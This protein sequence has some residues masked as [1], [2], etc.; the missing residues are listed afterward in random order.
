VTHE[1]TEQIIERLIRALAAQLCTSVPPALTPGAVEALTGLSRAEANL[2]FS[3]AGHLVH[4]DADTEPVEILLQLI[5]DIQRRDAA[6]D[7]AIMP[8]DEVRLVGE[9]PAS[10]AGYDATSL[11]ETV[12]VVRYVGDDATID[13]Q[14]D[15]TEDYLIETV[16]IANV[17][18]VRTPS[19]P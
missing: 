8:G 17:K 9:P 12:F 10:L 19:T 15:L 1:A 11:R 4:Y 3:H 7:A 6:A 2:I 14:P 13:V 5:S 16:S 18:R